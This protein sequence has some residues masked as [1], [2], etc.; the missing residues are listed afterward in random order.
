MMNLRYARQMGLPQIG[1]EGQ[2]RLK[3]AKAAVVGAGG[4]GSP[5]LYYLAAAGVGAI[6]IIDADSVDITNLNRQILHFQGDLGKEK[7]RSAKEKLERFNAETTIETAVARLD[8]SNAGVLLHGA[9][10]VISCVDNDETRRTLNA[11]CAATGTTLINGGVSGFEGYVMVVQPG[12]TPCFQCIFRAGG[13][14]ARANAGSGG[15]LGAAAGVVGSMMAAEAIKS[16]LGLPAQPSFYYVD[17]L[18]AQI[19]P[20]SA[21]RDAACPACGRI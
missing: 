9:G 18:S 11:Y 3:K 13:E 12:R 14:K 10:T 7:C 1:M 15:V 8:E 21:E 16:M 2:I 5:A 20:V 6:K 19:I 4:L 17:L